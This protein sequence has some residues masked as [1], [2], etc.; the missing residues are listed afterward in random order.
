MRETRRV[1]RRM[2]ALNHSA[3]PWVV[4][5]ATGCHVAPSVAT[6]L[7]VME[8][9]LIAAPAVHDPASSR[10]PECLDESQQQQ[11]QQQRSLRQRP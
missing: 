4:T 10:S 8:P 1:G 2:L 7:A 3:Y 9:L 6:L 11:Q 5:N